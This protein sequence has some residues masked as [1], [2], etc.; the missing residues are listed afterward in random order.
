MFEIYDDVLGTFLI[1]KCKKRGC[2]DIRGCGDM[3]DRGIQG[4]VA[5]SPPVAGK[6]LFFDRNISSSP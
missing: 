3:R 4:D 6:L 5:T 1:N 2:G